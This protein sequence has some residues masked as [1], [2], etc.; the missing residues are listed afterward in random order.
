MLNNTVNNTAIPLYNPSLTFLFR[1]YF[2]PPAKLLSTI[3]TDKPM[4]NLPD[5]VSNR[6]T[7]ISTKMGAFDSSLSL[8]PHSQLILLILLDECIS[9]CQKKTTFYP[10]YFS[11]IFSLPIAKCS[12]T[13]RAPLTSIFKYDV[14]I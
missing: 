12:L 8:L 9:I 14:S 2:N 13:D 3:K 6:I 1:P 5:R 10:L 7:K 11:P 4:F